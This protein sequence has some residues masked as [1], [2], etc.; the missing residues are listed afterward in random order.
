[1]TKKDMRVNLFLIIP[2]FV[3]IF[4]FMGATYALYVKTIDPNKVITLTSGVRYIGIYGD[5]KDKLR[6]NNSYNFI[7][8][9]RGAEDSLYEL[10]FIENDKDL[11]LSLI[12]YTLNI[13]GKVTTGT[14]SGLSNKLLTKGSLDVNEK[15]NFTLKLQSNYVND[16][17]I[18][19]Y[20][21][22]T[23]Q[24]VIDGPIYK[25]AYVY[26][27][28]TNT[29][30]ITGEESTCQRTK[31]YLKG[32]TC[33]AGTIV[34]YAV[35]DTQVVRFHVM[36]DENNT[37]V[38]QSQKN[39]IK[40][41]DWISQDDYVKAGGSADSYATQGRND[42]GPLSALASVESLTSKWSNVNNQTYT[43]GTTVFKTNSFTACD[44]Y[45]KSCTKSDYILSTRTVKG[46]PI[47]FQEAVL[48]GCGDQRN[49]DKCPIWMYNFLRDVNNSGEITSEGESIGY[50]TLSTVSER[51]TSAYTIYFGGYIVSSS[52]NLLESNGVR[53]VVVVNKI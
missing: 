2:L 26:S 51:N 29:K 36:F 48:L 15:T 17:S 24:E 21:K 35:N 13:N 14:L 1:M 32:S 31:C 19:L 42:K 45:D 8:E 33:P 52:V 28:D 23:K 18:R 34:D 37:L 4:L 43:L 47:S 5:N 40:G 16:E 20:T 6:L 7:L 53:P 46:R 25:R 39:L 41:I 22:T 27:T 10:Y 9:N 50:W 3:A 38:M 49:S 11:D 44:S 12:T 30:C